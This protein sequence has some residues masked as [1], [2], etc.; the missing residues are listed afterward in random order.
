[1]M[2]RVWM[3]VALPCLIG[4]VLQLFPGG[5]AGSLAAV[6][7]DF[8]TGEEM[9]DRS[10]ERRREAAASFR[11][12]YRAVR[13]TLSEE[14]HR[15]AAAA[16]ARTKRL[17]RDG[18]FRRAIRQGRRAYRDYRFADAAPEQA[19]LMMRIYAATGSPLRARDWLVDLWERY[20]GYPHIE[21]AMR[22]ALVCARAMSQQGMSINMQAERPQDVVDVHDLRLVLAANDL[23]RFLAVH[24]D[25]QEVA[26]VATLGL[27]RSLLARGGRRHTA[28]AR[29]AYQD[30]LLSHPH[31][32][33][34][35]DALMEMSISHLIDY[36]GPRF[37]VGVLIDAAHII[38][39]AEL[40]TDDQAERVDMVRSYRQQIR[41]WH[42]DRDLY[43]AEWYRDHREWEASRYY[44]QWVVRR[45]ATSEQGLT[46][47]R[48]LD[49]LPQG[50]EDAPRM[51]LIDWLRR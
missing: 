27:A 43:A 6:E 50:E 22:E 31:H 2:H 49:E 1:M 28:N 39:Q 12:Q 47:Q 33:L 25:R 11:V 18:D 40:Y 38:D 4:A 36:R 48:A 45:E 26:P 13:E 8:L 29:N 17:F 37:D 23:F 51:R 3:R 24:G 7:D 41:R 16:L 44:Y 34:V 42:Q 10:R 32:P 30:F 15:E 46:A 21:Q 20:P 9:E 5:P 19:H 14:Y 35:F